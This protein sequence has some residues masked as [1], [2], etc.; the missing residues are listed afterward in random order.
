MENKYTHEIMDTV[1]NLFSKIRWLQL[2]PLVVLKP[3]TDEI[4]DKGKTIVFWGF[5]TYIIKSSTAISQ[6]I[7]SFKRYIIL[8]RDET[9]LNVS[10]NVLNN[11][12][13]HRKQNPQFSDFN[14]LNNLWQKTN[15][16]LKIKVLITPFS[17]VN[18]N[19]LKDKFKFPSPVR[20]L[21][22]HWTVR[23]VLI[24]W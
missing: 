7:Y 8:T 4:R 19:Y 3:T 9:R 1:L 17:V 14:F 16:N 15:K 20:F 21:R 5:Q 2:F 18:Y 12:F 13:L 10:W 6:R 23:C 11:S 22:G 24:M